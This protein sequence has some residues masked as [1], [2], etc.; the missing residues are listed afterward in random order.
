MT[1]TFV[2]EEITVTVSL[3]GN[4]GFVSQITPFEVEPEQQDNLQ[5]P[6]DVQ[7]LV[8]GIFTRIEPYRAPEG[9][10]FDITNIDGNPNNGRILELSLTDEGSGGCLEFARSPL[11]TPVAFA[12][13]PESGWT[14]GN[15][16]LMG[17]TQGADFWA[18]RDSNDFL[19]GP[20]RLGSGGG[21][22][23]P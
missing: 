12:Q 8:L 4:T 13:P 11:N 5:V 16:F 20:L 21:L 23:S 17:P 10:S 3:D 22:R 7:Q 2:D 1:L 9:L 19:I 6:E 14:K 18:R 15:T